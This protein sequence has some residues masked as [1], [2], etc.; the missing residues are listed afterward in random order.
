M[1]NF[2]SKSQILYTEAKKKLLQITKL[3][4]F[5]FTYLPQYYNIIK[6]NC[7]LA[8]LIKVKYYKS[9]K[10]YIS[11]L[12]QFYLRSYPLSVSSVMQNYI[13]SHG[14]DYLQFIKCF[15]KN[16]YELSSIIYSHNFLLT[17]VQHGN[18]QYINMCF[19][20][21]VVSIR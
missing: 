19:I 11:S 10:A 21:T 16:C 8:M 1:V 12:I 13:I 2:M 6:E 4:I 20:K 5:I 14:S 18:T 7:K 3:F 15:N 9:P 17:L